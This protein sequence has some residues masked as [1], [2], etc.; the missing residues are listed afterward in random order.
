MLDRLIQALVESRNGAA[1]A[2]LLEALR[3]GSER[4]QAL[5]LAALLRRR[6]VPGLS[7]VVA[8]F[9]ALPAALQALVLREAKLLGPALRECGRSDD[10]GLRLAALR[11]I[12]RGRQ[13]RLAYVLS[14]NL[15]EA[16]ETLSKAAVDAIVE[17][18]RWVAEETAALQEGAEEGSGFRVQSSGDAGEA[19][20]GPS[21]S[22]APAPVTAPATSS[23]PEPRTLN[24]EPSS[25]YQLLVDQRPEIEAAV[26]RAMSVRGRYGA[27]LLRAALLLLDSPRSQTL[28]ILQTSKH[29]GQSL[30]VR[31]LQ[32]PPDAEHAA[33]F[34]I[35]ASHGGLRSHFGVV[36]SH[37][38][39]PPVLDAILRRT[40][41]LKDHQ[42]QL[43][44][45]QVTRGQWWGDGELLRDCERRAPA[46]AA[47]VGEW[48]AASGAHDV[49]QD[50][51]LKALLGR[52][53]DDFA[54]RLRLLRIA[55]RRRRSGT[56]VELLRAMLADAD[57]RLARMAA[58]EILR[59]RPSD[60]ENVLLHAMT[61]APE[62]V[63]KLIARS[64]GQVG[65]DN[66]WNRF[67]RLDKPTR[68]A[69]GRAMMKLL[70]DG[71]LRLGRRLAG[72]PVEQRLKALQ[73]VGEL[74]LGEPLRAAVVPLCA[75]PHP[76]VRSKAVSIL[77]DM[78]S[79]PP[80]VVL[81]K[82]LNDADPRV[83]ANAI[84]VLEAKGQTDYVSLLAQ[85]ARSSHQRE[86][87]N[88]I[89]AM[90][91]MKVGVATAQLASMLRDER[92]EHRISALWAMRQMGLWQLVSEVGRLA[93]ED[94]NLKVR[95][96][97]FALLRGIA[98]L[99]EAQ[100]RNK[101]G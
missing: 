79:V 42:L 18:A 68:R 83:R 77:G 19:A 75:H 13:G 66:F 57:E 63:R 86:R 53:R 7:G 88:A 16:D 81:D 39:D 61:A 70:P 100:Q 36:F 54:A 25:S 5:A 65:F 41:W 34:L 31:R 46:D 48:I 85:R 55:A 96:Y 60:F 101:A 69:A 9:D 98:E 3:V 6:T 21:S 78:T 44:L 28:Q 37:I 4:E 52:C 94:A 1:D 89:K 67:D 64:L 91:K 49:V 45:H 80:D 87:A 43:C 51:R 23:S 40:H 12:A 95:R 30:I 29:G 73:V 27:E 99:V 47:R 56:S 74:G 71:L 58:R 72:G 32:Q 82:V 26:A 97:A 24:P 22:S 93:K 8:R 92:P 14:E 50:E 10:H 2:V 33:A 11:I 17:L 76:R 38:D 59:R 62:S 90:H 15:H 35:G 84:E 20:T